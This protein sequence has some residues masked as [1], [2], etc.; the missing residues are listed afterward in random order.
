[1]VVALWP[2]AAF[3]A[4]RPAIGYF[5]L[6]AS[7]LAFGRC[8]SLTARQEQQ[9]PQQ[10]RPAPDQEVSYEPPSTGYKLRAFSSTQIPNQT[11]VLINQ[12]E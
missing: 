3:W 10:Q 11:I 7:R 6:S 1:M 8:L 4:C 9:H 12:W 5:G 2:A